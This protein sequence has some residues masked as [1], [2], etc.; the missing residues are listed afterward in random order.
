[1]STTETTTDTANA[2]GNAVGGA[3]PA[4][5]G[6]DETATSRA[7]AYLAVVRRHLDAHTGLSG[8]ERDDL[9]DELATHVDA[10]ASADDR[11]LDQVL[12]TPHEFAD[13]L[14]ASAG[15]A[16]GGAVGGSG[17]WASLVAGVAERAVAAAGRVSAWLDPLSRHRWVSATVDFL[18]ELRPAWWVAR[19]WMIVFGLGFVVSDDADVRAM[20]PYPALLDSRVLGLSLGIAASVA[21][22]GLARREPP[23]RWRWV[24]NALA[25]GATVLVLW[26]ADD[27]R[28]ADI[29]AEPAFDP[30]VWQLSHP[31]GSAITNIYA[32]DTAGEPVDGVLLY[33]Q[34]GRPIELGDAVDPTTGRRLEHEPVLDVFGLPVNNLY[35]V[36]QH[37]VTWGTDGTAAARFP[38][39]RPEVEPPSL[40]PAP[41]PDRATDADD[42]TVPD[43]SGGSPGGGPS[44]T[45]APGS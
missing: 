19:G 23:S 13:E 24:V 1:V 38:V 10:V 39:P 34:H 42:A 21:S 20:F 43:G 25:I 27:L 26:R 6:G 12:G 5:G 15:L 9:L 31:D 33:D 17:G 29:Y 32:Y 37:T 36:D 44:T 22:V 16:P 4:V 35:P 14:L 40:P 30:P 45:A 7:E 2:A 28:R 3:G 8:D 18:P 11:P 41:G